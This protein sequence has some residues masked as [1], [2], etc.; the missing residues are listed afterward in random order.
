MADS[1]VSRRVPRLT[2]YRT[3]VS[4]RRRRHLHWGYSLMAAALSFL[5]HSLE[6]S[7]A[8]F[9]GYGRESIEHPLLR[10]AVSASESRSV[11]PGERPID[12]PLRVGIAVL[13]RSRVLICC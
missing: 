10:G 3:G 6:L 7:V 1:E 4:I 13:T 11:A 5:K 12:I 9:L 8:I 2:E